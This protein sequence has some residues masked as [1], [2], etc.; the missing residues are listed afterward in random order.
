MSPRLTSMRSVMCLGVMMLQ[1]S[2]TSEM[3]TI[4]PSCTSL[5]RG[6]DAMSPA[7]SAACIGPSR[8]VPTCSDVSTRWDTM[9]FVCSVCV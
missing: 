3:S 6:S 2:T 7:P 1:S 9:R 8:C 5:V 4:T